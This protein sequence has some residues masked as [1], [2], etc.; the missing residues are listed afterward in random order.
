M[1][2][3]ITTVAMCFKGYSSCGD[4]T[5]HYVFLYKERSAETY[6]V[7]YVSRVLTQHPQN[8]AKGYKT[9]KKVRIRGN[10]Y[11]LIERMNFLLLD[12]LFNIANCAR[13]LQLQ[14]E[15]KRL[16]ELAQQSTSEQEREHIH[17]LILNNESETNII[18]NEG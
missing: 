12:T 13:L 14:E 1:K 6:N 8:Y 11:S 18:E 7:G 15:R 10:F 9:I 17:N 2:D 16:H 4:K 3:I 5:K